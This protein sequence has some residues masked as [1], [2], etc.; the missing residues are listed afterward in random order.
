MKK[1]NILFLVSF[2]LYCAFFAALQLSHTVFRQYAHSLVI[3]VGVFTLYV[4]GLTVFRGCLK[5]K[6]TSDKW[7]VVLHIWLS[8]MCL[9]KYLQQVSR[10]IYSIG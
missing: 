2:I 5:S 7:Y 10:Y 4:I 9:M 8:V 6:L 1:I 3:I